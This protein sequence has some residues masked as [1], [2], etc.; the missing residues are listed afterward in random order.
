MKIKDRLYGF[1][2]WL[3]DG[4]LFLIVAVFFVVFSIFDTTKNFKYVAPS[5]IHT[6]EISDIGIINKQCS[7][8]DKT[9]DCIAVNE[10]Y[11]HRCREYR[12]KECRKSQLQFAFIIFNENEVENCKLIQSRRNGKYNSVDKDKIIKTVYYDVQNY[13]IYDCCKD[14]KCDDNLKKRW[15]STD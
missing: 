12:E 8:F 7:L 11:K 13:I 3:G 2:D 6:P 15:H 14:K 9:I 5:E 10:N 4:G 1:L